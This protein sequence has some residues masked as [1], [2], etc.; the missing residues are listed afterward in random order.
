MS[1]LSLMTLRC[2]T[3]ICDPIRYL[4]SNLISQDF[5]LLTPLRVSTFPGAEAVQAVGE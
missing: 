4:L 2:Y 5:P 1:P 3:L